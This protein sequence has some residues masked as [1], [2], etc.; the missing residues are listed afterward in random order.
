MISKEV[1]SDFKFRMKTITMY[2]FG[3]WV[4]F[5]FTLI[6]LVMLCAYPFTRSIQSTRKLAK[7]CSEW[8]MRLTGLKLVV[9]GEENLT[10]GS[11]IL[12]A[13]HASYADPMILAAA[14]PA[15]FA[16]VAKKELKYIPFAGYVLGKLGTH[17]VD[18]KDPKKGADDFKKIMISS[19]QKDSIIFFPEATF[20]KE[21]GLLK[22]KK[23]AFLTAIRSQA[24]IVPIT[25]NGSREFLRSES[26]L[27]KNIQLKVTIHPPIPTDN[28][29][30]EI[31]KIMEEAR[32]MILSC[33]GEPDLFTKEFK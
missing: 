21:E 14:L 20:L 19:K 18:R 22:F 2:L 9:E 7:K 12:V 33:L 30:I 28:P 24:P 27:P 32:K 31:R 29:E 8:I 1:Y 17:L 5:I 23:G 26:W 13:N 6:L 25:I 3:S 15:S 4:W 10:D 16:F 11:S